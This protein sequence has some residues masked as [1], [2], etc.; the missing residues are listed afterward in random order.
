MPNSLLLEVKNNQML[1]LVQGSMGAK[2]K[3]H[4]VAWDPWS[5]NRGIRP[6]RRI[7]F[8]LDAFRSSICPRYALALSSMAA[9]SLVS[10]VSCINL[11][12][13]EKKILWGPS[14]PFSCIVNIFI[15]KK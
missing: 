14:E 11:V 2:L 13:T 1:H 12:K 7:R 3:R 4:S 9:P 5:E 10:V 15:K 6:Q 8:V